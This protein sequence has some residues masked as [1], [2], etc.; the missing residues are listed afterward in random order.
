[1]FGICKRY[2]SDEFSLR[3]RIKE[4][5]IVVLQTDKSG[6]FAVMKLETYEQA[7]MKHVALDKE[8]DLE[9]IKENQRKLNGHCSMWMKI[10]R[11]GKDWRHEDRHREVKIN[12]S[13]EVCPLYLMYKN[14]KGW[15]RKR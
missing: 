9:T 4:G 8:V 7:G 14:H 11:M 1:M 5:E 13:L 10:F 12:N 15:T 6:R 3:K 2:L